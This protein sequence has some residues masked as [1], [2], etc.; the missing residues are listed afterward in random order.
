MFILS[1]AAPPPSRK[2]T[3]R[4]T[5]PP[6]FVDARPPL[7]YGRRLTAVPLTV[8][9]ARIPG[10]AFM[11]GVVSVDG[12]RDLDATAGEE[13][14]VTNDSSVDDEGQQSHLVCSSVVH[15]Q[16]GGVVVADGRGCWTLSNSGA[17]SNRE[18]K[19]SAKHAC[20]NSNVKILS[21]C[22]GVFG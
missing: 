4:P 13:R 1:G 2:L 9:G 19:S 15:Q 22:V 11:F 16:S 5:E 3:E 12:Q 18:S 14:T 21:K 17:N 10:T 6:V 8:P 7:K 20:D